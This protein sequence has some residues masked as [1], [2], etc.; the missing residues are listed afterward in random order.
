MTTPGRRAQQGHGNRG[1]GFGVKPVATHDAIMKRLAPL[2]ILFLLAGSPVARA[3]E[4]AAEICGSGGCV[5]VSDPGDVGPLHSTGGPSASPHPAPF[6]VVR[7]R[8]PGGNRAPIVWSY[9]YV[10]SAGAMRGDNFGRGSVRW[11]AAPFLE[12]LISQLARD[13]VPYP[14]SSSWS[15]SAAPE[16]GGFPLGWVIL[17]ALAAAAP[18]AFMLRARRTR[19]GRLSPAP[20]L[21]QSD[22][23]VW[24]HGSRK[25]NNP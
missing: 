1:A 12:P 16:Q 25:M 2:I 8:S 23:A 18:L 24:P 3:K 17:A 10:P 11:M 19:R 13:L 6:Y 5:S 4:M 22:A 21:L 15:P 20:S 9:L 7:F 14:P